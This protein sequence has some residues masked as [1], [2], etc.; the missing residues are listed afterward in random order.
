MTCREATGRLRER[1]LTW[2]W[3]L[4]CSVRVA[5]L[6]SSLAAATGAG[7]ATKDAVSTALPLRCL[8]NGSG[9]QQPAA[10]DWQC[11]NWADDSCLCWCFQC[12]LFPL[13]VSPCSGLGFISISTFLP[14]LLV[15]QTTSW[16]FTLSLYA[17][18]E[19][20]CLCFASIQI[21]IESLHAIYCQFPMKT[22]TWRLSVQLWGSLWLRLLNVIAKRSLR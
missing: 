7:T 6:A 9:H 16:W 11:N 2:T 22:D 12:S 18:G 13:S 20:W 17:F 14:G 3:I 19:V 8:P 10:F 4:V 1:F 5:A 21:C 15:L